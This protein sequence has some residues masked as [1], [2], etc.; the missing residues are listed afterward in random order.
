MKIY[1]EIQI[2]Y[3]IIQG[4]SN[5]FKMELFLLKIYW[6][7]NIRSHFDKNSMFQLHFCD[8]IKNNEKTL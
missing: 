7:K 6:S 1:A 2:D 5:K 8:Q 4:A 3:R